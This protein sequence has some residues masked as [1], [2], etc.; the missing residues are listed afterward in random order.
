MEEPIKFGTSGRG[1]GRGR[2][3]GGAVATGIGS[4]LS[5]IGKKGKLSTLE[6]S[7]L[8]WE[9]FKDEQG[10]KE[11]LESHNKGKDG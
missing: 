7:K 3:R 9:R 2:R 5:Q 6:K 10:I 8:D 11:D 1:I 4:L